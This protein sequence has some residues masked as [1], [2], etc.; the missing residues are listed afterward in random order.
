MFRPAS[1]A[2]SWIIITIDGTCLV[3]PAAACSS[4]RLHRARLDLFHED[5]FYNFGE[6]L[7]YIKTGFSRNADRCYESIIF[8]EL[9]QESLSHLLFQVFLSDIFDQIKF[10]NHQYHGYGI[11]ILERRIG[12]HLFLPPYGRFN[13][14][15]VAY[16]GDHQCSEGPTAEQP[17]DAADTWV[18]PDQVPQLQSELCLL[19]LDDLHREIASHGR[20]VVRIK[21]ILDKTVHYRGLPTITVSNDEYFKHE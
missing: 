3:A 13:G 20:L 4:S 10:I 19:H 1:E 6:A 8:C 7:I 15:S 21:F 9:I 5:F 16:I 17:V 12:I 14:V 11:S 2:E 18:L